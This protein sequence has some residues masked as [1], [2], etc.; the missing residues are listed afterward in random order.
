MHQV[1]K[2]LVAAILPTLVFW[3]AAVHAQ[4]CTMY[5]VGG[6]DWSFSQAAACSSGA[7][8]AQ[9]QAGSGQTVTG[10][11][12]ANGTCTWTFRSASDGAYLYSQTKSYS[13]R[14]GSGQECVDQCSVRGGDKGELNVTRG[15]ATPAQQQ[16]NDDADAQGSSA[17]YEATVTY[18]IPQAGSSV[19]DSGC[20]AVVGQPIAAWSSQRPHANGMHRQS[21][22]VQITHAGEMCIN[23]PALPAS[24]DP[25]AAEPPCPGTIGE[26]NGKPMCVKPYGSSASMPSEQYESPVPA[27]PGNPSAGMRPPT[28][29][30][31]GDGPGRTPASGDGGNEGG[32]S[33]AATPGGGS[34][35]Y[36]A[37]SGSGSGAGTMEINVE[38]CGLPG[39]PPCKI[40]E[41][42]TP[43]GTSQAASSR[44]DLAA[45]GDALNAAVT[46]LTAPALS[47]QFVIPI[48]Q[49][50]CAAL[51]F[52]ARAAWGFSVDP[53]TNAAV[54]L[55]RSMV[56]WLLGCL[57]ALYCW[58]SVREF[59]ENRSA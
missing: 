8:A 53:C 47:W 34:D 38:T 54:A 32:G 9:A 17:P 59:V 42:G 44:A 31:S 46:G 30:G 7:A 11:V 57:S 25:S 5:R 19:C 13:Y 51:E 2:A 45:K 39:K 58:R 55:V 24:A 3:S 23:V 4:S 6:G 22:D 50:S 33:T 36:G 37:G 20:R 41:T 10:S 12:G 29:P 48:P 18:P 26:F 43:D 14:S 21:V 49:A 40:D 56:A 16:R 52:R 1:F 28:G 35:G 15:W 27:A